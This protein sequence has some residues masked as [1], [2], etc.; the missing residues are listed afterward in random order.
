VELVS[1]DYHE[2]S[3]WG[4]LERYAEQRGYKHGWVIAQVIVKGGRQGLRD[5]AKAKGYAAGWIWQTEKRFAKML[6]AKKD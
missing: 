3:D 2:V 1:E 6:Q 4:K 5:Y